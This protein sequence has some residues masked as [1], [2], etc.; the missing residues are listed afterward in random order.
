MYINTNE[1]ELHQLDL[2]GGA[3]FSAAAAQ[4]MDRLLDWL[5]QP[6]AEP[7]QRAAA[8]PAAAAAGAACGSDTL[9]IVLAGY[10]DSSGCQ[11]R[12]QVA[13]HEAF[14]GQAGLPTPTFEH[15]FDRKAT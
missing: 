7:A 11:H 13:L 5:E 3:I 15:F 14:E 6:Q 12:L 10:K 8:P 9:N 4:A 1:E 2:D